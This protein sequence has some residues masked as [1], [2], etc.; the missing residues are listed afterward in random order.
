MLPIIPKPAVTP[1]QKK[2]ALA[3]AGIID[4]LQN[5]RH[6]DV[7]FLLAT[8]LTISWTSLLP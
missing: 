1:G 2:A 3:T 8:S 7:A 5:R 6:P 4:L